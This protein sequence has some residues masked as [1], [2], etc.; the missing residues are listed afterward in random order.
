MKIYTLWNSSS[1]RNLVHILIK[2]NGQEFWLDNIS[3]K[4]VKFLMK[5]FFGFEIFNEIL[6]GEQIWD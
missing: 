5:F 6:F 3:K 1:V 2:F 4:F